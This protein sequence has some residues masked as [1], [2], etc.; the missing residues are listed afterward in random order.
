VRKLIDEWRA[1]GF[2]EAEAFGEGW[3]QENDGK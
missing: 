3:R 2:K 1:E